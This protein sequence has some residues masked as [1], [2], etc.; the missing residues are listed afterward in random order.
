MFVPI[1]LAFVPF[2]SE[3]VR[4]LF[5]EDY[6]GAAGA[7]S[8]LM[9]ASCLAGLRRVLAEGTRGMGSARAS[10]ASELTTWL[11]GATVLLFAHPSTASGMGATVA[12][13]LATSLV[14]LLV[15]VHTNRLPR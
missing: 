11:A 14:P 5:G 3:W 6:L 12:I 1:L 4:F 13:A 9:G 10:T 15:W 7:A 2:A 8:L